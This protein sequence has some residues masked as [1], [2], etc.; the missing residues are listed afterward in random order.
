MGMGLGLRGTGWRGYLKGSDEKPELTWSLV[1]R[2][3]GYARP[4]LRQIIEMFVLIVATTGLGLLV[5]LIMRYLIDHII[6]SG[7]ISQL[8]FLA[9]GMLFIPALSGLFRVWQRRLNAQIGEGVTY[10]LRMA[11][12][13][14]LQRMSLQFFTNT[15]MGE[16][17]SRMNNDV[18]GAQDAISN[19][20]VDIATNTIQS[21][22][23]LA[24]MLTLEWH[25]TIVSIII[26]PFFIL[27]S[28]RIARRLRNLSREQLEANAGMNATMQ[29]TLNIGGTL[30]VKLFG[31]AGEEVK[32][33]DRRV[34]YLR[35]VN[36]NR[37]VV[38]AFFIVI[39]GLVS[40][41]GTSLVYGIGG[42]M[43]IRHTF[44]IGTIVAFGAY[45]STLYTAL[46][47]L[48]NDP[49]QFATSVVSF[50]R[51]FEVIDL[52]LDIQEKDNPVQLANGRGELTFEDVSFYYDT[53]P[54]NLLSDVQ[55]YGQVDNIEAALSGN[56]H[57]EIE[58]N[59]VKTAALMHIPEI[60]FPQEPQEGT[61]IH[62]QARQQ[63][64]EH[65][66]F[67]VKPGDLTALV[68]PSGAGKTTITYL[69]PRL[70]DPTEGRI[71]LD[72]FD[73]RD[74]SLDSLTAQVGMVTQETHL[75]HDTIRTNLLYAKLDASQTEI[76]QAARAANI[77]DFIAGLPDKYETIVGERGY[78]L[79]G[80]EKQRIALA[81]VILKDPRILV[82]D[83]ATSSL[84]SESE[85][86]IQEALKRLMA[87]RTSIV[88][89]HRLS[90]ILAADQILV[91]DRGR[92]VE[93]GTHADLLARGGLYAHLYETQFRADR[94]KNN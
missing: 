1:R 53:H 69:I 15:K 4:Y 38:G 85:A 61:E 40:A 73:L 2:V 14:H 70:Y 78:R 84:D 57:H 60:S 77:H 88:I 91:L 6:P 12:Y 82:L 58:K 68:G 49:V 79:S 19:T 8:I 72:G 80:G 83:E 9:V 59:E 55:R 28:R 3:A 45:L 48:A 18:L 87:G 74:L 43:V 24:V 76:E 41:V 46:Q 65:I 17:I 31:Q 90:T 47:G 37:A 35:D 34:S 23:V 54:I 39:I 56:G 33:F 67:T 36:I 66:N 13:A 29:E 16:L 22:A 50:E 42:Y 51:V 21:V 20:I 10:D 7:N 32:R 26:L 86:L 81:R 27:V 44:T 75:F 25:L 52:P 30:L 71:L 64:L 63:A 94:P 62:T 92:I 11:I 89:A 93:R 5:P